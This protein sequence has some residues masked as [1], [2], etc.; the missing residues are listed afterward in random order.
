MCRKPLGDDGWVLLELPTLSRPQN[1]REVA[2]RE[3]LQVHAFRGITK[4]NGNLGTVVVLHTLSIG[5]L[6]LYY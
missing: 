2:K 1:V 4:E 3:N 5:L 6:R